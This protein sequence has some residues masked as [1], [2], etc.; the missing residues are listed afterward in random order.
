VHR[1]DAG[2]DVSWVEFSLPPTARAW[3][4]VIVHAVVAALLG[5]RVDVGVV[6][7]AVVASVKTVVVAIQASVNVGLGD[8]GSERDEQ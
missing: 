8:A 3:V 1:N 5:R 7:V 6:V 2:A 4:A